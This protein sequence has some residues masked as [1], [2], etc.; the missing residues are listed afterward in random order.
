VEREVIIGA[1]ELVWPCEVC[2]RPADV[3]TD[4]NARLYAA[5]DGDAALFIGWC[6]SVV[7]GRC[8]GDRAGDMRAWEHGRVFWRYDPDTRELSWPEE[9]AQDG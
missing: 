3:S 5:K 1:D 9:V 2:G 4:E 8:P 6:M 7:C